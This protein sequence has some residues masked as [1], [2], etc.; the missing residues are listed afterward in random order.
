M[1]VT[2]IAVFTLLLLSAAPPATGSSEKVVLLHGLA[3]SSLSM[4]PIA[5]TLRAEGYEVY[6]LGYASRSASIEQH[7]RE[8]RARI[9]A[10]TADVDQVHFVTNSMGGV[11][12]RYIQRY[13]PLPN[14]GRVVMISPPNH[15]SEVADTLHEDFWYQPLLGPAAKQLVT[16]RHSFLATLG[17]ADFELG[18]LT[19]S[20][21]SVPLVSSLVPGQSDGMVSVE[22]AQL[23]GMTDFRVI[24]ASHPW[25]KHH[26]ETLIQIVAFLRHGHFLENPTL[27]Q[28]RLT[29]RYH[30]TRR[31][32]SER[33][34]WSF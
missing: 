22:S 2:S 31:I 27:P 7:A 20:R 17:P 29:P 23:E 6:N 30:R 19:G 15:G 13:D 26:R 9:V 32:Q 4:Q 25:I 3:E 10:K 8:L 18:I 34:D 1:R 5:R 21:A 24:D 14:I 16:G 33:Y 11:I 12:V 28:K